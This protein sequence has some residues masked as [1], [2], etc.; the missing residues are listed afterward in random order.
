M[1]DSSRL[2]TRSEWL[3]QVVEDLAKT[4]Y[5]IFSNCDSIVNFN[6]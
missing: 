3:F 5:L 1:P 4:F 2:E 6:D